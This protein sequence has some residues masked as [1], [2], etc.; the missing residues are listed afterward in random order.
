MLKRSLL[1]SGTDC[2]GHTFHPTSKSQSSSTQM[3]W[4]P[5]HHWCHPCWNCHHH[6]R[7]IHCCQSLGLARLQT[8]LQKVLRAQIVIQLVL[9][10]PS[11]GWYWTL[12]KLKLIWQISK[13]PSKHSNL[14]MNKLFDF[15]ELNNWAPL[16]AFSSLLRVT[17][18]TIT[19]AIEALPLTATNL[20]STASCNITSAN[21]G[22]S[23]VVLQ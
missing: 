15:S 13:F 11:K 1:M 17:I 4:A 8:E 23:P 18:P 9:S 10:S 12:L 16:I 7:S 6:Q 5:V 19:T 3:Q 20:S 2:K 21:L 22:P 14:L